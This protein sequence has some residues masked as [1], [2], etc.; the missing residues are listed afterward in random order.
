MKPTKIK[1]IIIALTQFYFMT[2]NGTS[3]EPP[4][5][6]DSSLGGRLP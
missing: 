5:I 2:Q 4:V 3:H 1:L 6:P